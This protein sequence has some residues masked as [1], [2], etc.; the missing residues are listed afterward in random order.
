M[1]P[2]NYAFFGRLRGE[3][4]HRSER[5]RSPRGAGRNGRVG[6]TAPRARKGAFRTFESC[7]PRRIAR[8]PWFRRETGSCGS[9]SPCSRRGPSRLP[10][11]AYCRA[12]KRGKACRSTIRRR[13]LNIVRV[14]DDEL[15]IQRRFK[16][17]A[18]MPEYRLTL[19]LRAEKLDAEF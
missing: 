17:A 3:S 15:S 9:W 2:L 16:W 5:G 13:A 11:C 10:R 7:R 8:G 1:G 14:M 4:R 19:V 12:G 18:H 6:A